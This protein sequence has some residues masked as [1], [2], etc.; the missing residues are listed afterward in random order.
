[1]SCFSADWLHL[2][3]PFDL[4][5]R[6]S[7]AAARGLPGL[8][9]RWRTRSR[10]EPL[11]VIDLA[12][13]HGANLRALAPGLG[14]AQLWRLFDHD[15]ALL[16]AVPAALAEWARRHEYRCMVKRGPGDAHAI[17]IAGPDFRANVACHRVD[18]ACDL[19]SLDFGQTPL[20][21]ASALL[22]LVSAP[23]LAALIHKA[24]VA[25]A[26]LLFGLTVDGRMTWNPVDPGDELVHALFSRHQRRDKGFGPALGPQAAAIAWQQLARA[27]FESSQSQ[28]DWVVDGA[29]A[30]LMQ[31]AMVEGIAAAALEQD[32][33][34][35]DAVLSWKAR[36]D[37]GVGGSRLRVGHVDIVATPA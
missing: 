17:E 1:M 29:L 31:R 9:T 19:A 24:H 11:A 34:A 18:L 21:T 13:G 25:R 32:L 30:P 37:A 15:P 28:T 10:D 36:R 3:E 4:A 16:A 27:G 35:K 14:R 22:D 2:R 5:A 20:V 26:A 8:L 12:C 23:W 6:E 7:T 33:A